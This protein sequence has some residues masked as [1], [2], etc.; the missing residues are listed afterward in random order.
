[1]T[2]AAVTKHANNI[3]HF[4]LVGNPDGATFEAEFLRP[5]E[6]LLANQVPFA[7][8][9]DACA[10]T[11]VA[12]SVAWTMIKWM[13]SNRALLKMWLRGTGVVTTNDAVKAIMDFVFSM[14]PPVAPM[15]IVN[16]ARDAWSFVFMHSAQGAAT[17]VPH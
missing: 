10:V 8:V 11:G 15:L 1:M 14:Q 4:G 6:A 5:L 13:R 12:M 2:F 17:E 9:V 7:L 16:N 3:V